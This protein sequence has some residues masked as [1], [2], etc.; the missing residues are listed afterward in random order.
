M[1]LIIERLK[2]KKSR[3]FMRNTLFDTFK[4]VTSGSLS[5]RFGNGCDLPVNGIGP[6]KEATLINH[7]QIE[8]DRKY[9]EEKTKHATF[10]LWQYPG[11]MTNSESAN[12][13]ANDVSNRKSHR[14]NGQPI[15]WYMR[16]SFARPETDGENEKKS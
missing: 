1:L 16:S 14:S 4:I 5:T 11:Q 10:H 15:K 7:N 3:N 13:R 8:F 6:T 12:G 9:Q 2:E